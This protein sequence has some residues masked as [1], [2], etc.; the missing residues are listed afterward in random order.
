MIK[1][2]TEEE[3]KQLQADND[4]WLGIQLYIAK[5]NP[6]IIYGKESMKYRDFIFYLDDLFSVEYMEKHLTDFI[7]TN[8]QVIKIICDNE[9]DRLLELIGR[10]KETLS[11]QELS[12]EQTQ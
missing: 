4:L 12:S 5:L 11:Q 6:L 2:F 9:E 8:S 1:Q 7:L 3:I 10:A